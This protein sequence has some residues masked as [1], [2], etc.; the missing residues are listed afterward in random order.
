MVAVATLVVVAVPFYWLAAE[1]GLLI[2]YLM[3]LAVFAI[4]VRRHECGRCV[5]YNCPSNKVPEVIKNMTG[6]IP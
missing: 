1:P 2:I 3:S 4:T 5:Y 6:D